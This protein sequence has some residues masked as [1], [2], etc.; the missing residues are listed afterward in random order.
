MSCKTP[1]PVWP[2]PTA[3]HLYPHPDTVCTPQLNTCIKSN[4]A[5]HPLLHNSH[6]QT[7]SQIQKGL[8][9]V[10][11]QNQLETNSDPEPANQT[12]TDDKNNSRN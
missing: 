11:W 2:W 4:P 1:D 7:G 9:E 6:Q 3:S 5:S 8:R 12:G 10:L